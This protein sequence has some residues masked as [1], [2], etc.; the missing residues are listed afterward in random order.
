MASIGHI[1]VGLAAARLDND[2]RRPLATLPTLGSAAFW[3]ALSLFPDADVIG[4]GFGILYSSILGHRGFTHSI[5]FALAGGAFL[6]LL[7]R[8]FGRPP[9]RTF[10]VAAAVLL[11]HSL[12]DM[13]TDGGLGCAFLWPLSRTRYFLP[14]TPIPVAPI[15]LAFFSFYGLIV[16]LVELVLFFPVW[17]FALWPSRART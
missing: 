8:V 3:S 7:A 9:G 6:A 11:S 15:G 4:F 2:P 14:W 5:G 10:A 17:V 1:A 12:L 16:S 13:M